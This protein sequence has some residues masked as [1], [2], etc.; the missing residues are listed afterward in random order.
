MKKAAPNL[1][2]KRGNRLGIGI[3]R[4]LLDHGGCGIALKL[5]WLVTWFYSRFDREAFAAAS[6]YLKLR[7]PDDAN[8][9][10]ALERHFHR[11]LRELAE[12]LIH[13]YR[14]GCGHSI[15]I[16]EIGAENLPE[17]GGVIVVLAHYGC[18]QTSMRLRHPH[19]C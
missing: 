18:W 7:F 14:A 4:F 1:S 10:R 19:E 12:V 6:S 9:R 3:F 17:R 5:A 11:Q 15:P 8:D 16:E 13:S 2:S